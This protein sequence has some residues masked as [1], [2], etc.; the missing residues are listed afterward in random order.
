VTALHLAA[1]SGK[2]GAVET[3]VAAGADPAI[4]DG[5]YDSPPAGWAD[6]AGHPEIAAYL[7][8]HGG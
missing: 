8:A 7:R 3:L 2:L 6:H 4:P 1:Q 5:I